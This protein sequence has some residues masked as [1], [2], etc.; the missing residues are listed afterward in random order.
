MTDT[1]RWAPVLGHEGHYIISDH[2]NAR[3][4]LFTPEG[5]PLTPLVYRKG[6][7]KFAFARPAYARH[8]VHRLVWS[9]FNGPIPAGL[10]V[11]HI[12]G[13]KQNNRL[14]NLELATPDQQIDHAITTGL[15]APRKITPEDAKDLRELFRSNN[16]SVGELARLYGVSYSMARQLIYR[17]S[18]TLLS[19]KWFA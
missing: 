16:W 8:F 12:D 19:D 9:A 6:Y 15:R 17:P 11:N 3:S 18:W 14:T 7:L 10:T 4:L 1:E 5:R 2:G 13:I